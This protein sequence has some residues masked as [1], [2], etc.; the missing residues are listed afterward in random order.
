[1]AW[2]AP[3]TRAT[4]ELITSSIWNTDLAD[5]L[6][7][8]K[9]TPG[10]IVLENG[11][12]SDTDNLDD[13]GTA[14]KIWKSGYFGQLW[15]G[16]FKAT[17]SRRELRVIH[18]TPLLA[19]WQVAYATGGAGAD[20]LAGGSGQLVLSANNNQIGQAHFYQKVEINNAKDNVWAVAKKPYYRI[21]FSLDNNDANIMAF[22]GLRAIPGLAI[23]LP[24]AEIYAGIRWNGTNWHATAGNGVADV[25]TILTVAAGSRHVFEVWIDPGVKVEFWLDGVRVATNTTYLP[26]G[27]LEWDMVIVGSLGGAGVIRYLTLGQWIVQEDVP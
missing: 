2:T 22:M 14:A 7:Y 16:R 11:I 5:N 27:N 25:T 1:M 13:V 12:V 9:G 17:P 6:R 18:E 24:A 23:P 3:T 20:A 21:E 15:G 8:L 26:S 4:G 10:Q 19:T